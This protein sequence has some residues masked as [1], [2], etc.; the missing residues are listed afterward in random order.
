MNDQLALKFN[1]EEDEYL[2]EDLLPAEFE[3]KK[4]FII[5]PFYT[6]EIHAT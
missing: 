1:N 2:F 5:Q 4:P 6:Y 3:D